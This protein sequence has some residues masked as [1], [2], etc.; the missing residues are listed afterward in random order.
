MSEEWQDDDLMDPGSNEIEVL[1]IGGTTRT[2]TVTDNEIHDIFVAIE[3]DGVIRC[4]AF[5]GYI[6]ASNVLMVTFP[7]D[8]E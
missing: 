8:D 7:E 4:E 1:M 5:N 6:N 3:C 2:L